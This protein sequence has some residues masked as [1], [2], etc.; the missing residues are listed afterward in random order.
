[1]DF[2]WTKAY[3]ES[4][5]AQTC[6]LKRSSSFS[7]RWRCS[8]SPL[9]YSLNN[10]TTSLNTWAA[11]S[12]PFTGDILL[13]QSD[14]PPPRPLRS[15]SSSFPVSGTAVEKHAEWCAQQ[16]PSNSFWSSFKL[17]HNSSSFSLSL[18]CLRWRGIKRENADTKKNAAW[19]Q[20][21][22][23]FFIAPDWFGLAWVSQ[24]RMAGSR[25]D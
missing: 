19:W 8:Q 13:S 5:T 25:A 7:K 18:L 2:L 15:S 14:S 4:L 21:Q 24:C 20:D 12:P 17:H 23:E 22:M 3:S 9:E 11:T 10:M 1:M 16:V 6:S